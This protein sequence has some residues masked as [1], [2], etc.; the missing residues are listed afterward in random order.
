VKRWLFAKAEPVVFWQLAQWQR[1][2]PLSVPVMVYWIDW[3]RHE[4]DNVVGD[5]I[6]RFVVVVSKADA[7][8]SLS[9]PKSMTSAIKTVKL[10][11]LSNFPFLS[12]SCIPSLEKVYRGQY[13]LQDPIM[14]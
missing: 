13:L 3:Q 1:T 11:R 14:C 12:C 6:L 2:G 5:D 9:P 10:E 7:W 4:P 8:K